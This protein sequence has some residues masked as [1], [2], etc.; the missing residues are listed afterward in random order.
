MDSN[1]EAGR[2]RFERAC[3]FDRTPPVQR[4]RVVIEERNHAILERIG[5]H[6][7]GLAVV[8]LGERQLGAGIEES[9]KRQ[10]FCVS[11]VSGVW[12]LSEEVAR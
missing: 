3:H 7:P 12:L 5:R 11:A 4:N 1:Y 6:Q 9:R 2:R 10:E 8:K